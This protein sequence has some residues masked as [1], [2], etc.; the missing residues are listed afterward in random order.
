[1]RQGERS[2]VCGH[3]GSARAHFLP[4]PLSFTF[5]YTSTRIYHRQFLF[6]VGWK[7]VMDPRNFLIIC[8]STRKEEEDRRYGRLEGEETNKKKSMYARIIIKR[9]K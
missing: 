8:E 5:L 9:N 2:C 3:Q 6:C 1:M 7:Y 4:S